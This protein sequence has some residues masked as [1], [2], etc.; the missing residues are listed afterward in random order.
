MN[1][2]KKEKNNLDILFICNSLDI[3]SA[4]KIMY[5]VVKNFKN[6]KTEIICLTKKGHHSNLIENENIKI[7]Y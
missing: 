7:F 3:G 4:E 1:I 2:F 5:E 6:Y